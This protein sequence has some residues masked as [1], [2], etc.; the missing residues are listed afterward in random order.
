RVVQ[1]LPN[2]S[3]FGLMPPRGISCAGLTSLHG[4][5]KERGGMGFSKPYETGCDLNPSLQHTKVFR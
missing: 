1:S 2:G 4:G 3:A 5:A